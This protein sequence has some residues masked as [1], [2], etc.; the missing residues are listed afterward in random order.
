MFTQLVLQD[1]KF[2]GHPERTRGTSQSQSRCWRERQRVQ[3]QCGL[4]VCEAYSAHARSLA[5]LG[6]TAIYGSGEIAD[7]TSPGGIT[8]GR[9]VAAVRPLCASRVDI[10]IA[11]PSISAAR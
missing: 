6:M 11:A 1:N 4:G 10:T 2:A 3:P 8:S 7:A 9:P 5:A